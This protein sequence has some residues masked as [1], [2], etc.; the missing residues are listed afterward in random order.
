MVQRRGNQ[1]IQCLCGGSCRK[2]SFH[3]LAASLRHDIPQR[4]IG[5]QANDRAREVLRRVGNEDVSRIFELHA[6]DRDRGRDD[7]DAEVL[8]QV[9]LALDTGTVA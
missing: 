7:G 9:D 5:I 3:I 4:S 8:R 6:F 2:V 1:L